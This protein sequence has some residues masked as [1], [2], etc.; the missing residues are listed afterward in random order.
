MQLFAWSSFVARA[1]ITG[2]GASSQW[3]AS[4]AGVP[5]TSASV[6]IYSPVA[7]GQLSYHA[8]L[9]LAELLRR[10]SSWPWPTTA[11][12]VQPSRAPATATTCQPCSHPEHCALLPFS[13]AYQQLSGSHAA[14]KVLKDFKLQEALS[15]CL[16]RLVEVVTDSCVTHKGQW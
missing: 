16:V 7:T 1:A 8:G 4:V 9:A 15:G 2:T 3:R 6:T 10:W 5:L 13:H 12:A 11:T 14:I